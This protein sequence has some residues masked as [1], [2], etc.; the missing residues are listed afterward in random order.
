[1]MSFAIDCAISSLRLSAAVCDRNRQLVSPL[2]SAATISPASPK[3]RLFF[4]IYH[5][6]LA[7]CAGNRW[8]GPAT[9]ILRHH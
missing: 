1:M 7:A 2:S 8:A 3:P 9:P 6:G 4:H 5:D